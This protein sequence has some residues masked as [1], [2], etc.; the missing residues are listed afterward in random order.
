VMVALRAPGASMA[1]LSSPFSLLKSRNVKPETL[2]SLTRGPVNLPVLKFTSPRTQTPSGPKTLEQ[3]ESALALGR[4]Y[5]GVLPAQLY[6]VLADYYVL[7][8]ET[9]YEYGVSRMGSV[10]G[11]LDGL[12]RT[13]YRALRSGG[14]DLGDG[15]GHPACH[16]QG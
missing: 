7:S 4:L 11:L 9:F 10:Y 2:T 3:G 13:N 8:V 15:Q 16:Q 12:T 14:A 5:H 1:K 6:P